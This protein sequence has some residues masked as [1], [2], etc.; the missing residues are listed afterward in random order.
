[1][2][3]F[4]VLYFVIF[5][6]IAKAQKNKKKKTE[7]NFTKTRSNIQEI[8]NAE[9]ISKAKQFNWQDYIGGRPIKRVIFGIVLSIILLAFL[10]LRFFDYFNSAFLAL[11]IAYFFLNICAKIVQIKICMTTST[12]ETTIQKTKSNNC[13]KLNG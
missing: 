4:F 11:F 8:N 3:L 10:A 13:I 6:L 2:V 9:S 12:I 5:G 7:E 1:M